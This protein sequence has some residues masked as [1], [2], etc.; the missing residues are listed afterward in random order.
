MKENKRN[1][2][3]IGKD[4]RYHLVF[5]SKK[6]IYCFAPKVASS[7]WKK[8]LYVL[9]EDTHGEFKHLNQYSPED[10]LEMLENYF[11]FLFVRD[12]FERLLSAYKSKFLK[13][14]TGFFIKLSAGK[15]SN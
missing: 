3:T 2:S 11:T 5:H 14:R 4:L 12:P 9:N 1:D 15:S 7:Q 8:E 13:H 6:I 10:A